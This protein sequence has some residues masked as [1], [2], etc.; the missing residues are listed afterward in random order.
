[1]PPIVALIGRPDHG[2]TTLLEK[3]VP[4]LHERGVRVGTIKHHAHHG[5][6]M[7]IPGKDTWRHRQAGARIVALAS[8]SGL[9]MIRTMEHDSDPR[10][11]TARYFTDVDLVIVEGYKTS[12]L[13]KIEVFRTAAR[14]TPPAEQA[15]HLIATISDAD[16]RPGLPRFPADDIVGIADFLIQTFLEP[17]AQG[18]ETKAATVFLTVDGREVPLNAFVSQCIDGT[19][20]GLVSSLKGCDPAGEIVLSLGRRCRDHDR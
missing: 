7:D 1:M 20:R 18:G 17:T 8:P 19:A 9:G 2:K 13:A 6:A 10:L 5:F 11:L 14:G 15:S 12:D 4:E 16:I 3:L